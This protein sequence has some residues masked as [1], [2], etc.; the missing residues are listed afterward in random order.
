MAERTTMPMKREDSATRRWDPWE[1]FESLQDEM[2]RF[3]R[4]PGAFWTG[5]FPQLFR[6]TGGQAMAWAPRIDMYEKDNNIVVKAELPG[7]KKEDVQVEVDSG[8]L[9]IRGETSSESEV[10]EDA[11]YRMERSAG[12]FFRRIPL[13]AEVNPDQVQATMDN[14]VLEVRIPKPSESRSQAK[15]IPI[16]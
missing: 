9:V 1:M 12:T 11:Y 5:P 16:R 3:W 15:K 4:R 10:K 6:R 13:P 8:N 7:L 14:G 2:D